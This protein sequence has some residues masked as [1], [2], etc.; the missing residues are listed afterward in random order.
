MVINMVKKQQQQQQK[1]GV[2]KIFNVSESL[3][4]LPRLNFVD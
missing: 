2:D 1:F 4:C 3:L